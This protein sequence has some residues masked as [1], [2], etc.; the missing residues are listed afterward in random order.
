MSQ[1]PANGKKVHKQTAFP[2]AHRKLMSTGNRAAFRRLD[3]QAR[4]NNAGTS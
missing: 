1:R 4:A 3:A 2:K